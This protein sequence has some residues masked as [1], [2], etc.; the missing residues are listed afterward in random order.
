MKKITF[1]ILSLCLLFSCSTHETVGTAD[2][3]GAISGRLITQKGTPV[4]YPVTVTLYRTAAAGETASHTLATSDGLSKVISSGTDFVQKMETDDGYYVFDSLRFGEYRLSVDEDGIIVANEE[5][6][7][8][9]GEQHPFTDTIKVEETVAIPFI[10]N[11]EN[12]DMIIIGNSLIDN[13]RVTATD[14]GYA[15][16][17]IKSS[18]IVFK[19]IIQTEDL[20]IDT[21]NVR[22]KTTS[23]TTIQFDVVK[24]PVELQITLPTDTTTVDPS[25]TAYS[26]M[27]LI[28]AGS[29]TMGPCWGISGNAGDT[30]KSATRYTTLTHDFWLDSTEVTQ[31]QFTDVMIKWYPSYTIPDWDSLQSLILL[32][33]V[34]YGDDFPA[35]WMTWIDGI[36]YCNAKTRESGST[37]TVYSYAAVSD[38]A[39]KTELSEKIMAS[40]VTDLSRSG[41]HLPT[42]AQ[43]EY[44][45]RAGTTTDFYFDA[46][47]IDDNAWI[48]SN[49]DGLRHPVALKQPN[50]F[51]LYDMCGNVFEWCND[52]ELFDTLGFQWGYDTTETVDPVGPESPHPG[53][54]KM[55]RGGA[56][57]RN[58]QNRSFDRISLPFDCVNPQ[59]GFRTCK[60]VQ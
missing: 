3:A 44:A 52:N 4:N 26:G 5:H 40:L 38:Y 6:I 12:S 10:V 28:P 7:T 54:M 57:D 49:S 16:K 53:Y 11:S 50:A 18:E 13:C 55:L 58:I 41:F 34:G 60:T 32:D 51:G 39:D 22:A 47:D 2:D 23:D 59:N 14:S 21:V 27:K 9:N 30:I 56:T 42:E 25:T 1:A 29:L 33:E 17:A 37:D 15:V 20:I 35:S 46:S 19:M 48:R 45:C 31:K 24:S 8:V 43:W 36:L